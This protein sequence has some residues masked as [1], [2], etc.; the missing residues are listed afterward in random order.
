MPGVIITYAPLAAAVPTLGAA[1]TTGLVAAVAAAGAFALHRRRAAGL[2][3]AVALL[4]C[5]T[6]VTLSV[7]GHG[8]LQ[9]ARAQLGTQDVFTSP[10]G[11]T[12]T[13]DSSVN[14]A[15]TWGQIPFFGVPPFGG[16][17]TSGPISNHSGVALRVTGVTTTSATSTLGLILD[18]TASDY[19]SGLTGSTAPSCAANPTLQPGQSCQVILTQTPQ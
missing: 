5:A 7:S 4:G 10:S 13:Y 8:P 18:T 9:W 12:L 2:L 6:A 16:A 3:R 1:A 11:G 14:P 17:L 19:S 15:D